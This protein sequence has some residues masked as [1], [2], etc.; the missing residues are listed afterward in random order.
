MT[1]NKKDDITNNGNKVVDESGNVI[2]FENTSPPKFPFLIRRTIEFFVV[3]LI[4][5]LPFAILYAFGISNSESLAFKLMGASFAIFILANIY[6]L[7][8]FYYSMGNRRVY[9]NVNITS[10]LIFAAVNIILLFLLKD[11]TLP[12]IYSFIFMPTKLANLFLNRLTTTGTM[13]MKFQ[14]ISAVLTHVFMLVVI[15]AAP[16]EMYSFDKP[17][18]ARRR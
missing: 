4:S 5:S 14:L 1:K 2:N 7:R 10:Y 13:A 15:F 3:S 9:F 17:K 6:F 8:V 16:A 18:S 11:N 12:S